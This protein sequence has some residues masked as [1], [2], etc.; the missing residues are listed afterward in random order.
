MLA[1]MSFAEALA[2]GGRAGPYSWVSHRIRKIISGGQT[3]VDRAALDWAIERGI[4]HGGWCPK[5]RIAED[6]VIP[7]RYNLTETD[8]TESW[9]RTQRNVRESD[10]TLIIT[11]DPKLTGGS[12]ETADYAKAA[13]KLHFHISSALDYDVGDVLRG[14]VWIY[15]L[16]V[17]NV[18]GSRESEETGI[19]GFTRDTLTRAFP[20]E[21]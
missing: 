6:G 20:K 1:P 19:Y 12:Q 11:F 16:E 7:A 14:F 9:A 21:Q 2:L 18:A 10:G 3:G 8:E 4:E 15:G 5:G 13:R 17:V